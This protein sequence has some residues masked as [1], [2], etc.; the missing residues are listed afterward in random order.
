MLAEEAKG[1][2]TVMLEM[3]KQGKTIAEQEQVMALQRH[4]HRDTQEV[5]VQH[6]AG[7]KKLIRVWTERVTTETLWE[8]VWEKDLCRNKMHAT[9]W[10][11]FIF[12]R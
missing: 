6:Q 8:I 1:Q 3:V 9:S 10:T 2:A 5:R 7:M 11:E 12:P 4:N